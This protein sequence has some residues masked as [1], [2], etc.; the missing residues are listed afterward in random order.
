M[1]SSLAES[2]CL[3]TAIGKIPFGVGIVSKTSGALKH[4]KTLIAL[5]I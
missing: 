4:R 5:N 1:S 2:T 3:A